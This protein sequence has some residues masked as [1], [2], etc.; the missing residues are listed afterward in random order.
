MKSADASKKSLLAYVEAIEYVVQTAGGWRLDRQQ[1]S[2]PSGWY[3]HRG[4]TGGP[5][6]EMR[7]PS[8]WIALWSQV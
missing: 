1:N 3:N 7:D 4:Y 8:A 6:S 2:P 5:D